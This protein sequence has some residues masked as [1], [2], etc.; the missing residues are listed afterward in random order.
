MNED[1]AVGESC[2]SEPYSTCSVKRQNE[3]DYLLGDL[4]ICKRDGPDDQQNR[5]SPHKYDRGKQDNQRQYERAASDPGR[6]CNHGLIRP[7][8]ALRR[9][10]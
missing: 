1:R 3:Q 5:L 4:V 7:G 6:P 8:S 9:N 2:D 10:L